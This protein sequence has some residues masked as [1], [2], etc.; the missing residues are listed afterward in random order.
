MTRSRKRGYT[1]GDHESVDPVKKQKT[2][3]PGAVSTFHL[4]TRDPCPQF[5][6]PSI[7]VVAQLASKKLV[8]KGV[9]PRPSFDLA[10]LCSCSCGLVIFFN[11]LDKL[12]I[13]LLQG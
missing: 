11:K 7:F 4:A 3:N 6:R 5:D 9:A 1:T 12:I 2:K 10:F 13:V 8:T